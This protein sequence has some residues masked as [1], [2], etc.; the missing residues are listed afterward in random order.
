MS[1]SVH[2]ILHG[3]FRKHFAE[4]KRTRELFEAAGIT[5]VAPQES[6]IVAYESGFAQ[7]EGQTDTD[8]RLIEL[9]YLQ[10]LHR[11]GTDGFSYF[12]NPEGYVGR[13]AAY[14]LGVAQAVNVP[15]FF[16]EP[17]ADLPTYVPRAMVR[18]AAELAEYISEHATLPGTDVGADERTLHRLW[19]R[20]LV[21]G[22]VVAAGSIIEYR[23]P[24]Y[25]RN[26]PVELLF[27]RTHK[28]GD[29]FS[30]VGDTLRRR[31]RLK[32]AL[33]RSVKTETDLDGRPGRHLCTFDQI[34]NS[35]YHQADLHHLFV[36]YTVEVERKR[37]RLN[38]EAQAFAWLPAR[39]ALR[40]L[41]LEPNARHTVE[42]YL[43]TVA[44]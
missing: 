40:D 5:V 24:K 28:W 1:A 35:G 32:Q 3:S 36:D 16:A 33:C 30:I 18:P 21:P 27:V 9:E 42:R 29:Q 23:N 22:S 19:Q 2:C 43:Q 41:P 31:E 4:I 13:S 37:V 12:V 6:E 8:P 39:E 10:H 38:H 44:G 34:K 11:L 15:C 26:N 20:L 17:P 14:E 7:F 25:S